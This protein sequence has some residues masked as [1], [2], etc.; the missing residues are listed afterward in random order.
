LRAAFANEI[1]ALSTVDE[2]I[3]L[4]SGDIGNRMFD[5]FKEKFPD[6]FYNCG[7]AEANMTGMAAGLALCGLRPV[8]Y[9]ITAFNTVR[10][11][12]Q[13]RI[14]VCF[15]N[16]PVIIVG[17]GGG[18]SYASLNATHH[19]LEDIA[20]LRV[21]PNMTV[22][23][24]GDAWEVRAA[25]RAALKIEGPV[26][27]RIAKKNEPLIHKN[28][29]DFTIGKGLVIKA[30]TD[31]CF[32]NAGSLL[33]SAIDAAAMLMEKGIS[34][35]VVSMHTVKPL[36]E[37]LLKNVFS[38]FTHVF[39]LEEHS[40]MGGFG[41]SVAEWLADRSSF[42]ARLTR[43]GTGDEFMFEAGEQE[44]ARKFFGISKDQ[45][46]KKVLKSMR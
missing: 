37:E 46:V 14:D 27:I 19:A 35:Q 20:Y 11:L 12:E 4:L 26:Y 40:I 5:T 30:G 22:I 42:K 3:V 33:P 23:C 25:I 17:V 38:K 31:F 34:V 36:D 28:I 7:V 9:T 15:Q 1:E 43:I 39:T 45:I 32:L 41:S 29:P 13:I 21:L 18:L 10:C 6:R 2:R 44:H 24:P 8:T 16:L